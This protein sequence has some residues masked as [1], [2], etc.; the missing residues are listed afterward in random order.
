MRRY[1]TTISAVVG[2]WLGL[3]ALHAPFLRLPYHWDEA[4]YYVPAAL[5]FFRH[6][7]LIPA[8]TEPIGHTPL[9]S[10][11]LALAWRIFGFSPLVT[12]AAMNLFAAATV[13]ATLG[14]ARRLFGKRAEAR[15]ASIAAAVLLA[16]APLFFAQSEMAHLDLA[17]AFFTLLAVR[18]LLDERWMFFAA[19]AWLATLTKET[20][21]VLVPVA[22]A[23]LW[24]ESRRPGGKVRASAWIALASPCLPLAAWALYYHHH[25]GFWTGNAG[26]LTYNLYST[27]NPVR[28]QLSF[29]RR[30]YEV[31][32]SG[33]NWLLAALAFAG[34][35]W[36]RKHPQTAQM[37]RTQ[38]DARTQED[39]RSRQFILL[40]SLLVAAY[41]AMLSAVGGAILPRYTLP[42]Y[43]PLMVLAIGWIWRLPRALARAGCLV[44]TACLVLAWFNNPPYPFPYEDNLA[45]A[46]FIR[47]HQQAAKYLEDYDARVP[48]LRVLTAWPATNELESP[49]LGYVTRPL[50]VIQVEGFGAAD[51][52]SVSPGSFDALYLYS[53]KWEPPGNWLE[54]FPW[55][56]NLQSRYFDYA[57]Q[58]PEREL[59]ARLH[60]KLAARWDR[61]GQWV[62]IYR[63]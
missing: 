34:W 56:E 12:R 46:D 62:A 36:T 49:D 57:P 3:L 39:D 42:I 59:V 51:L 30:F 58:V 50:R 47:L 7:L 4:G 18:A 53:R 28:M 25:T 10:V 31:F 41:L 19:A 2:V 15:E 29:L 20:A 24:I 14:L 54:R 23:Y 22:W 32:I 45:F 43:P 27:L 11:Y 9:V 21:I 63:P 60:L 26:Y 13:I 55:L 6:G 38:E 61:R 8:S 44:A 52:Q 17:V 5:D 35:W 33:F 1:A 48:G 16:V 40:T 37:T